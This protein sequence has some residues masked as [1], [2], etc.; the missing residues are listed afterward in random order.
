VSKK[1]KKITRQQKIAA[2]PNYVIPKPIPIPEIPEVKLEIDKCPRCGNEWINKFSIKPE[3][4]KCLVFY[5]IADAKHIRLYLN[6]PAPNIKLLVWR[7]EHND[8]IC[9]FSLTEPLRLPWLP[10][11]IT[12]ERLK[13][14]ILFS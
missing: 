6:S 10:F 9:W 13:T 1:H 5:D 11:D 14:L 4:K 3:C 2:N 7:F 8:C 12:A